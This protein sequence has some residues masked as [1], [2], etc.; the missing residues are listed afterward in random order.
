MKYIYPDLMVEYKKYSKASNS[1]CIREFQTTLPELL[2]K[3]NKTISEQNFLENY[4]KQM[5]VGT[6]PCTINRIAWLFERTFSTYKSN[7]SKMESFDA[8]I[9]KSGVSYSKNDYQK[10]AAMKS[11]YEDSVKYYQQMAH[12]QRLDKEE[13]NHNRQQM[14]SLFKAE[15]KR[16]LR[17]CR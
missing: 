8:T 10:I 3:P 12:K 14:L 15:C 9:L 5:P 17:Y 4:Q 7:H 11:K 6:N 13:V 1:K 16:A 2:Q